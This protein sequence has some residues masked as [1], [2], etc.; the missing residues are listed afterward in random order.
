M[1]AARQKALVRALA[2]AHKQKEKVGASTSAP[3]VIGKG[4]SK[5]KSER[6]NDRPL[7]KGPSTPVG[8]KQ[9]KQPLP[10][11]PS[12]GVG[13]GLMTMTGPVTQGTVHRFLTH[14]EHV[15]EMVELIIKE[16]DLDPC[17]K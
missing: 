16:M 1:E 15:V 9:L 14:K 3:K 13:K 12:Q 11:K 2:V 4:M 7:K 17:V 8:D 10:P 5:R 6:K